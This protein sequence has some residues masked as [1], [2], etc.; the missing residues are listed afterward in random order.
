[1]IFNKKFKPDLIAG[2]EI[3]RALHGVHFDGSFLTATNGRMLV[4][5]PAKRDE[6]DVAGTIPL[7]VFKSAVKWTPKSAENVS[8]LAT[9]EHWR[10]GE[11]Q[12]DFFLDNTAIIPRSAINDPKEKFPDVSAV[13]AMTEIPPESRMVVCLNAAMLADLQEAFGAEGVRLEFNAN[14][15][16]G[17]F[18]VTPLNGPEYRQCVGVFMPMRQSDGERVR[19]EPVREPVAVDTDTPP[20]SEELKAPEP[21]KA[22]PPPPP[23]F[24]REIGERPDEEMEFDAETR[25][26]VLNILRETKRASSSS[27]Q[28][29]LRIGYTRAVRIMDTLETEGIVGPLRGSEPR[30]ILVDLDA[31]EYQ[32]KPKADEPAAD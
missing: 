7:H 31:P 10:I 8:L 24:F 29:R 21:A 6:A 19:P 12:A 25:A 16:T 30:E 22:E 20:L 17:A 26:E 14:N 9:G 3:R 27:I 1:M 15:P 23:S 28:R 5:V 4:R 2:D 11:T 18:R 13:L 32:P